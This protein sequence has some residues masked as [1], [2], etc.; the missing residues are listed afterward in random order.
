[1]STFIDRGGKHI[2]YHG[3][4]APWFSASDTVC[5]FKAMGAAD[6]EVAAVDQYGRPYLVPGMAHCARGEQTVDSFDLLTPIIDWVEKGNAP[7]AVAA[8]G[9]CP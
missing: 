3:E 7:G 5:Y 4:A 2:F 1:V 8:S 9:T 6:S